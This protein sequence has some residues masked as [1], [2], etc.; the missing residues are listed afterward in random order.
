MSQGDMFLKMQGVKSG[1]IR[2]EAHD[3]AHANEIDV[4]KWAW[5][6]QAH[7]DLSGLGST[8]KASLDQLEVTKHVDCASTVL[9]SAL[10]QNE[11]IKEAVLTV[12]KAGKDALEY[13]VVKL[14]KARITRLHLE[15]VDDRVVEKLT[16]AYETVNITYN[17]QRSEGSGRG[18]LVF[19]ASTMQH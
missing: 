2:G 12:R 7:T 17:P 4:L 1:L 16:I 10:V 18:A 3:L 19:E 14:L 5:G 13:F 9:M 8:G 6:A 15:S 11:I